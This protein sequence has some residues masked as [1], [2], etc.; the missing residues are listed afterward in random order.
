VAPLD[1]LVICANWIIHVCSFARAAAHCPFQF[2]LLST[3]TPRNLA[4][5]ADEMRWFPSVR[6]RRGIG[7]RFLGLRGC[8]AV[9]LVISN[10]WNYVLQ[11]TVNISPIQ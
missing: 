3:I 4:V 7:M 10:S 1:A 2:S 5:S 6:V 9:F 11:Y 8:G